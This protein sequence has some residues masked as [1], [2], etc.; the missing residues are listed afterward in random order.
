MTH[1]CSIFISYRRS[2]APGYVRAMMSHLQSTFGSRQVFLD[3]K[4]I[5]AGSDFVEIIE[6]AVEGCEI[7]I[8]VIG[9]TW[10]TV[11]NEL[12][13]RRI[14][15]PGDFIK[16]EIVSAI[17]R[18]IPVIP[19]LVNKARM[20]E[21]EELPP[22]LQALASLQAVTLSHDHWDDDIEKLIFAIENRVIGPRLER[23]YDAGKAKLKQ[24]CWE[25]ALSEFNAVEAVN[26][27][28]GNIPEIVQPLRQLVRQLNDSGPE[29]H[30][31][32]QCALSHPVPLILI[33]S[34]AP[35]IL[36]AV[37]N[38]I[39]NWQVIVQP[40]QLRGVARAESIFASYAVS[41]NSVFFLFGLVLLIWLARPVTGGL[42]NLSRGLA[43]S[44][45]KLSDLRRRCLQ[46]G[47]LIAV[48]GAGMWI[49]AGPVYPVL[50]GALEV[51]DYVLFV[52]SLA[53]SGLTVA[54]YPFMLV[55]WLCTHVLYRPL[56][57]P[58]SVSA[59]DIDSLN[60]VE[61][62]KWTYFM[63][64]G[65]LPML[66][67]SLG[68]ILG[69]LYSFP[70]AVDTLLGIVGLGGLAGFFMTLMLFKAIQNDLELLRL[71]LWAS[72]PK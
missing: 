53:I 36:A 22:E 20:P 62:R 38:F 59:A 42:G 65:A 48:I 63:F 11:A 71:L 58:G 72:G 26:P 12:G 46:L 60:Q 54:A 51:R 7:L 66:V 21:A 49:A 2:D 31:W 41:V 1:Q 69:P 3:M 10:L 37:F 52:I 15:D 28:Y 23:Q 47:H 18:K 44:D 33:L 27:G 30:L 4:A 45:E 13:Q 34:L 14:D 68:F 40:M 24:G 70:Q 17:H 50:I 35:H 29:T 61:S 67:I 43:I 57:K 9:P 8:A 55:T 6:G 25:D 64:A 56:V 16:L 39:F 5:E 19:V 32:Q